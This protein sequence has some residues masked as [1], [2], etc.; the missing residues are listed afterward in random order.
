MNNT[1]AFKFIDGRLLELTCQMDLQLS[2]AQEK[3]INEEASFLT[4]VRG[5]CERAEVLDVTKYEHPVEIKA[6]DGTDKVVTYKCYPCPHCGK[7]V[8]N[9]ENHRFCE[10][11]GQALDFVG[12][13]VPK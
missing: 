11:C 10:W 9:N 4:Y 2:K 5:L 8:A 1:E 12:K 6:F 13:E 3:R 7:W